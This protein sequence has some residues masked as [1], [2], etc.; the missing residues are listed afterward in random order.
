MPAAILAIA[1]GTLITGAQ[2]QASLSS[3]DSAPIGSA[4]VAGIWDSG[5]GVSFCGRPSLEELTVGTLRL[6]AATPRKELAGPAR[7]IL[8]R[9][10]EKSFP[11]PKTPQV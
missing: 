11:C 7:V 4:Y 5:A 2:L 8:H 9:Q 1:A 10:L 3:P 6:L